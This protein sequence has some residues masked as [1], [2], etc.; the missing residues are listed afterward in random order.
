[1]K[2]LVQDRQGGARG[3]YTFAGNLIPMESISQELKK[4]VFLHKD[5]FELSKIQLE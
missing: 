1:L 4:E 2:G 5:Q 3:I